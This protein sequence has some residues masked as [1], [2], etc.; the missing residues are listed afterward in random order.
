MNVAEEVDC[1]AV[2]LIEMQVGS[3]D[4]YTH[5]VLSNVSVEALVRML[6]RAELLTAML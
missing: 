4:L 2:M 6:L 5:I 1:C 3:N